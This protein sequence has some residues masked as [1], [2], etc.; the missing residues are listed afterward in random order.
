MAK[1]KAL[2]LTHLAFADDLMFFLKASLASLD[3]ILLCLQHF[4][5]LSGLR[6]NPAKSLLFFAGVS[7]LDKSAF[8]EK[9][10][11]LEG[12]LPVKYLGLPLILARLSAHHCN[13]MLDL[14]RKRL[15]LWK[16]KLLSYAGRLVLIKSV[17]ESSYIYWSGIFGLPQSVIKSMESLM[18]SFLWKG[19][20][21]ARFLHP[22]SW[23]AG[24]LIKDVNAAG[25]IK[26]TWKVAS[27]QKSI[28]VDWLYSGLLRKDSIWTASATSDASWVWRKI[29]ASRPLALQAIRSSIGDG[30]STYLWLDHWHPLGILFQ[31]VF[32]RTIHAL[33]LHRLS[34][35]ADSID[36]DGWSPPPSP[37]LNH[38][39]N[40]LQS[41][42]RR[43]AFRGDCVTWKTSSSCSFSSKAAW[44]LIRLHGSLAPWRTLL[45]FKLHILAI[46]SQLGESSPNASQ[47]RLFFALDRSQSPL[48]VAS[49]GTILKTWIT[50]FLSALPL[51]PSRKASSPSAGLLEEES[52]L[53]QGNG[54]GLT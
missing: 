50:S 32:P 45:W 43:P 6:I 26:L 54:S 28:W 5:E 27:K 49:A 3:S 40:E 13:P 25:I 1:C 53:S 4:H 38:I 19:S 8:L 52:S 18:A 17:L 36:Q 35:V 29:L 15:Q 41:I 16:G 44:N 20:E 47:S 31:L 21:S 42:T 10:G 23:A 12:R 2:K 24:Q 51:L 37:S 33:G 9:S 11:F 46:A 7:E 30:R 22:T 14:I 34:L 39:W 48:P